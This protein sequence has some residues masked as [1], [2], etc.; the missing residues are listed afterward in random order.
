MI[1]SFGTFY[2]HS[3]RV[4]SNKQ[5]FFY[6]KPLV[7]NFTYPLLGTLSL[8]FPLEPKTKNKIKT[9]GKNQKQQLVVRT[10]NGI[11]G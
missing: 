4:F 8:E 3:I 1:S 9:Q 5:N 10:H 6:I 7:V 11:L 2:T